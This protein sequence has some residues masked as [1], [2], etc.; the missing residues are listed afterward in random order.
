MAIRTLEEKFIHDLADIYDA[1]H[2]FLEAQQEMV[3]NT[4]SPQ[5]KAMIQDHIAQTQQQ[6]GNLELIYSQL[7]SNPQRVKCDAA[8]GLVIEGQKG[9]E[10]SKGNP[11]VCD[12]MIAGSAAKVEHYE[13]ASYRSLIMAA[14]GMGQSQITTLLRQNL[15]QEEQTAQMVEQSTPLLLQQAM[16]FQERGR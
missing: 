7:G 16:R 11:A 4:T 8:T 10:E 12:C 9:I 15:R 5:L 3:Q 13:V 2:R 14:E 1:E 6:I